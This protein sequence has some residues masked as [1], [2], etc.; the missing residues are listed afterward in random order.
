M[1]RWGERKF[2]A[3]VTL[4][5]LTASVVFSAA[6]PFMAEAASLDPAPAPGKFTFGVDDD[7][8]VEFRARKANVLFFIDTSHPMMFESRGRMPLVRTN[9]SGI[10]WASTWT[11]LYQTDFPG[12]NRAGTG[13]N[14]YPATR[15]HIYKLMEYATFGV[16]T[17]PPANSINNVQ[18]G[19]YINYGLDTDD[20]NNLRAVF[21]DGKIDL[22]DPDNRKNYY[23][24]FDKPGHG[25]RETFKNQ[26]AAFIGTTTTLTTNITTNRG[27]ALPH[28]NPVSNYPARDLYVYNNLPAD[29]LGDKALPYALVFKNP[30][31]W[32]NGMDGQGGRPRYD[33]SNREH[34][35]ELVPNDSRMY[36]TK[37]A[38]WRL[39]EDE[40]K[41]KNINFGMAAMWTQA[42]AI[43]TSVTGPYTPPT[44]FT[45]VSHPAYKIAP[46][47]GNG[48][49]TTNTTGHRQYYINQDGT[50]TTGATGGQRGTWEVYALGSGNTV[51]GNLLQRAYLRVP[52]APYDKVWTTVGARD[53]TTNGRKFEM[54]QIQRFRQW[55]DGVEDVAGYRSSGAAISGTTSANNTS[56]A[57]AFGQFD[58][59]RNPELK[60]S[61]ATSIARAIIPQNLDG[62]A[63][64]NAGRLWYLNNRGIAYAKADQTFYAPRTGTSHTGDA[65]SFY[66]KPGSGQAVGSV[67]DF[68]SPHPNF[69][70]G[71]GNSKGFQISGSS[72]NGSNSGVNV[73]LHFDDMIP[74]QF[75][76]TSV[77]DENYVILLTAGDNGTTDYPIAT[78]IQNLYNYTGKHSA[79]RR[80]AATVRNGA[81]SF[82]QEVLDYPIKTIVVGFVDRSDTKLVNNL[83]AMARAGGYVR[84]GRSV[85][86]AYYAENAEE[87]LE[88]FDEIIRDI[89][90]SIQPAKGPMVE[91]SALGDEGI[92]EMDM[93]V[94]NLYAGGFK[95]NFNDQWQGELTRH[96]TTR[97][98]DGEW[99]TVPGGELNNRIMARRGSNRSNPNP[100]PLYIWDGQGNNNRFS[101]AVN[102]TTNRTNTGVHELAKL[103]G[104]DNIVMEPK[105]GQTLTGKLHPSSAMFNWYHGIDMSYSNA[106]QF[107]LRAFMLSDQGR[108]GT[109]MVGPPQNINSTLDGYSE[110]VREQ[111]AAGKPTRIYTQGN[112]GVLHIV[113]PHIVDPLNPQSMSEERAILPPPTLLPGRMISLKTDRSSNGN[114]QWMDGKEYHPDDEEKPN[115]SNP[116]YI[117][118]G[119]L[120]RRNFDIGTGGDFDWR[121]FVFGALGRGGSG[122]YAMDATENAANPDFYWYRETVENNDDSVTLLWRGQ[123]VP[124][125]ADPHPATPFSRKIP[126]GGNDY[127][128]DVYQNPKSHAFEQLGFNPPKPHFGI[129]ELKDNFDVLSHR[130]LIAVPGGTQKIPDLTDNGKMGAAFYLVDPDVAFHSKLGDAHAKGPHPTDPTRDGV[131]VFNSGSLKHPNWRVAGGGLS[132]SN[133]FMG[134]VTSEPTFM[135]GG[136]IYKAVGA[137]F[138]DNRG[139]I[140]YVNFTDPPDPDAPEDYEHEPL[141]R[142]WD[143]WDIRTVASLQPSDPPTTANYSIPTGLMGAARWNTPENLWV[144]GGTGDVAVGAGNGTDGADHLINER[145]MIF[146]F[147]MPNLFGGQMLKRS[148]VTKWKGLDASGNSRIE[149]HEEDIKGWDIP[150]QQGPPGIY[151]DEYVNT[152]PVLFEGILLVATFRENIGVNTGV[153]QGSDNNCEP[154]TIMGMSRLYALSL[155]TGGTALWGDDAKYLQFDG[156]KISGFTLSH[157]SGTPTLLVSYQVLDQNAAGADIDAHD[158]NERLPISSVRGMD[159]LAIK[160]PTGG[161][162]GS[163]PIRPNDGIVNYWR[164]VQQ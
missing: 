16:G 49:T 24:P 146:A 52:I 122:L 136:D 95:I 107:Q 142:S 70:Q 39:L 116:A 3:A 10:D 54:T 138:A 159:M 111:A 37:V 163:I 89:N 75:P 74:E 30:A 66:F 161:P 140:F 139:S 144:A 68:F 149:R 27:R 12:D 60:V 14:T 73:R 48:T 147:E 160:L 41:F 101:K 80:N 117:L 85:P 105:S 58:I 7:E 57:L 17:I 19:Q 13:N 28:P 108:S 6:E 155:D 112:D 143:S 99:T 154:N 51:D 43:P 9:N 55:I 123:G 11:N 158:S 125:T 162:G 53:G 15:A 121:T 33:P 100:R 65:Y 164:F 124:N 134:M 104:L 141:F 109:V 31:Y 113:N 145:Q 22:N 76:I 59:H 46:W 67:L 133:P 129:A 1:K 126:T 61:N 18:L 36:Q 130:N 106:E 153:G 50:T 20:R 92:T 120:Q 103:A 45:G 127:W 88:V 23:S 150:L 131:L 78:A 4:I 63:T 21:K 26:N 34:Q 156:L 132:G 102:F 114:Y 82:S 44:S 151:K 8:H 96:V 2:I 97:N 157:N 62:N 135:S 64:N 69:N 40:D 83:E 5:A 137:L 42:R 98:R 79:S 84:P 32:E 25:L 93:E 56:R 115:V 94:L 118:D 91:S 47:G 35:N 86:E 38:L 72:T 90:S 77:C 119:S 87:L 110:F 71:T 29:T 81:R 128:P 152:R 148:D